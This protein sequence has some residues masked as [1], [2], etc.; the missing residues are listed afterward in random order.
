[1]L[2]W[3]VL[4]LGFKSRSYDTKIQMPSFAAVESARWWGLVSGQR[5]ESWSPEA[6]TSNRGMRAGGMWLTYKKLKVKRNKNKS[7]ICPEK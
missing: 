1:M 6:D 2:T 3:L 7:K 4:L 5:G